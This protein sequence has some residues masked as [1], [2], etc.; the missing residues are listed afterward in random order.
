[1]T[2]VRPYIGA[3]TDPPCANSIS[4]LKKKQT[5]CQQCLWCGGIHP[6]R[7]TLLAVE[8]DTHCTFILLA[9]VVVER[10]TPCT[11]TLLVLKIFKRGAPSSSLRLVYFHTNRL[12][13]ELYKQET[14]IR[15]RKD[16][17]NIKK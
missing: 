6:A 11:P 15:C 2:S 4:G 9:G 17:G 1:V 16:D 5:A 14:E 10:N 13:I 12:L 3:P 8:R 7:F